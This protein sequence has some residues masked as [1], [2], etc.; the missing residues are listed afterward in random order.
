MA[1][2]YKDSLFRSLFGN[3]EAFLSLYNAVSG[4]SYGEDTEVAINTL[5][6]TLFTSKKNDVS[7][8]I[9]RK[10][11]VV[12]EHQASANE[13]MPFRF[14]SPIARL[15]ENSI[16]DKNAVYRQTLVKLPRP[17]FIVLY[18]G[19][20]GYPDMTVLKLS[21]AF[22]L[23]EGNAAVNLELAVKVY[24]IGKGRNDGMVRKSGPLGGYVD[25]VHT[26]EESLARI[27]RENPGIERELALEK[28]IVYTVAY[29]KE[30]SILKEFLENLS[31]EEVN[32]VAAEWNIDDALRVREEE[33]LQ[34]GRI[35]GRT[36]GARTAWEEFVSLMKQGDTVEQLERMAPSGID[37]R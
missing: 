16:S 15:F 14:L 27:R 6:D 1:G 7:G 33:S 2:M 13:N 37:K 30:H 20:A 24:N 19:S 34:R 36:E 8:I 18:N 35:E 5:S 23:V 3:K 26:A 17:E 10:L 4:S 28:A 32:M 9:D 21:D 31:P 22:E 11:V 25:F 29:C 12:A